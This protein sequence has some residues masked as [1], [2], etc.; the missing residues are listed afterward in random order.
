MRLLDVLLRFLPHGFRDEFGEEMTAMYEDE[1][2]AARGRGVAAVARLRWRTVRSM[3]ALAIRQH[4]ADFARDL[5]HGLRTLLRAPAFALGAVLTLVLGI[6]PAAT[7]FAVLDA[8]VLKPLPYPN[9]NRLVAIWGTTP[10]R[11]ARQ[12]SLSI[13]N[14]MD[15]TAAQTSLDALGAYASSSFTL[16]GDGEPERIRGALVSAGVLRALGVP[17]AAGRLIAEHEDEPGAAPVALL[18]HGLWQRRF[19]GRLDTIGR[20]IRIDGRPVL[21]IGVM[22]HGFQFPAR[23]TLWMPLLL[24][25]H[26]S[27]RGAHFAS[28]IGRLRPDVPQAQADAELAAIAERIGRANPGTAA[29]FRVYLSSLHEDIVGDAPRMLYV[30]AGSLGFVLL[31]ACA[32]VAGLLVVRISGR[33]R[34]L[35][36]RVTLGANRV[37]LARQLLVESLLLVVTGGAFAWGVARWLLAGLQQSEALRLPRLGEAQLDVRVLAF[38]FVVLAGLTAVLTLGGALRL[39]DADPARVMAGAG[40]ATSSARAA[41]MRGTLVAAQFAFAL[42]LLAGAGLLLRSTARLVAVDPGFHTERVLTFRVVLP[43]ARYPEMPHRS[44]FYEQVVTGLREIPGVDVAASAAYVPM[45]STFSNRRFAIMGRPLP[46]PGQEPFATDSPVGPD[47]FRALGIPVLA[48]R[49]VNEQDTLDGRPVIVVSETFARKHFPDRS[50]I[51]QQIRFY[52][53]RP[54]GTPPPPREIVGIVGDV[55]QRALAEATRPQFYVPHAQ[56]PWGF[57]SFVLRVAP[58]RDALSVVTA[59]KAVIARIDPEQAPSDFRL[60]DEIVSDGTARHRTLSALL[61]ALAFVALVLAAVGIYGIISTTVRARTQEIAVRVALGAQRGAVLRS[62]VFEGLRL[63]VA[64]AAAGLAG[65]AALTRL[66]GALLFEV[67]PLDPIVFVSGVTA[68][69]LVAAVACAWPARRALR[70]NPAEALRDAQ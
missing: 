19:G 15:L 59:A 8:V 54:G 55:R 58:G 29:N 16:A 31:V 20:S 1:A 6:A 68:L 4:S 21:I 60:A 24:D 25:P 53:G 5:R 49:G 12:L 39:A 51:G 2:R 22:P 63:A 45:S 18:S 26:D 67:E 10:D 47:Y 66:M 48:G 9:S 28:A 23:A 46:E 62:L 43:T 61:G 7:M 32:N 27:P 41:R 35:A 56:M 64:G 3:A 40:R 14:V 34:E 69:L 70:L 65:A 30:V 52:N 17:A 44:A 13:P 36:V 33:E 42:V 38:L 37:R 50:A 57:G 11:S